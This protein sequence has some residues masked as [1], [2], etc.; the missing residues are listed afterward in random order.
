MIRQTV[1]VG[2]VG[3]GAVLLTVLLVL[4]WQGKRK[5]DTSGQ[6]I[7]LGSSFAAGIGLGPRDPGSPL[8]CMRSINGYPQLLARQTKLSLVDMTCSG[9]TTPHILEGGQVFLGPQI[10]AVGPNARLVT[11]TSGGNDVGYIGDMALSG[12][13]AG[14]LGKLFWKE[15]KPIAERDFAAV[16]DNLRKIAEQIRKRAPRAIVVMVSYPA[17]LPVHGTCSSLG[18]D[19]ALTD[20]SRKVAAR[21]LEATRAAAEQSGSIFVDMTIDMTDASARH[22]A[23][24]SVP[25][26][27]GSAPKSGTA[28]HPNRAGAEATAAAVL[29]AIAGDL[30]AG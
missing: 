29:K 24:A 14:V 21:L 26:V 13:S 7:A 5:P 1:I 16:T 6:Y 12:G 18:L 11:I 17:V 25:W 15:P 10:E 22:D 3:L 20:T 28:F 8:V 4:V 19:E 27:N 23:C 9:S 2:L 30:A